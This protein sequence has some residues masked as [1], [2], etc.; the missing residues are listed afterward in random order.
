MC[1]YLGPV[2]HLSPAHLCEDLIAHR[3]VSLSRVGGMR[4]LI[5]VK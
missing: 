1:N 4:L 3:P 5:C 2:P